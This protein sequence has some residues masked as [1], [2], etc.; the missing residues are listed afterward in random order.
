MSQVNLL[1]PDI[2]AAQRQRRMAGVVALAGA[3]V[4]G[5]I[6]L[7]YVL[8]LGSLGSVRE[9]IGRAEQNN[10]GLQ[11]D[12]EA[13]QQFEEIRS[14][15]Q[16]KQD[17]LNQVY[18][19]EISFSGILMDVS[20][21]IPSDAALTSFSAT[22]QEPTATT[23]GSTLLTGRIDVAGLAI[24]YDTIASWLMRLERI[25]G[26]VNPWVTSI[27]DPETGPITYASGVDLTTDVVTERGQQAGGTADAG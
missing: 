13:L 11:R 5:L 14:R 25:R 6:F 20:R 10:A 27:A 26:W 8:Q 21:V 15:A 17:L 16:A 1:P 22:S 4:I 18:A 3:G 7:F 2:L 19:N 12:I 23:G 9:D 24:D